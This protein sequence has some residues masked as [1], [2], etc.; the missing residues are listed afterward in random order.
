MFF[1][2]Y[3]KKTTRKSIFFFSL[4]ETQRAVILDSLIE[5]GVV[6]LENSRL[7]IRKIIENSRLE[8]RKI[9]ENACSQKRI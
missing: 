4:Q 7:E 3:H 1:V 2:Y 8:I 5:K 9:I 6:S